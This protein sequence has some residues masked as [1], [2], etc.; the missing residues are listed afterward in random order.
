M[1]PDLAL[2]ESLRSYRDD[3]LGIEERFETIQLRSGWT[4]GVSSAPTGERRPIGWLICHSFGAEHWHLN[5][6]DVAIARAL[7]A[8]G[9]PVLRFH[10]QGYGDSER[11]DLLPT[12]STHV[13]D[14]TDAAAHL[15]SLAGVDEIGLIGSRFGGAVA[16]LAAESAGASFLALVDPVINGRRYLRNLLRTRAIVELTSGHAESEREP[17]EPPED[18]SEVLRRGGVVNVRGVVITP[19]VHEEIAGLDLLA[20]DERVGR[21]L[22]VQVSRG[23][24]P[25]SGLTR[26][27]EHLT[28]NGGDVTSAI[29]SGPLAALFGD[30]HFRPTDGDELGDALSGMNGEIAAAVAGWATR[31]RSLDRLPEGRP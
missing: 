6:T 1:P 23:P 14:A 16:T 12:V 31:L 13:Q 17:D 4:V 22:V 30:G 29:V 27:V 8:I 9:F 10:S 24:N 3:E 15:R 20:I 11:T 19:D 25:A 28:A 2:L 26:L 18:A 7:S 5:A 21:V